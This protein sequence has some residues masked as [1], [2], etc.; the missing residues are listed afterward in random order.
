MSSTPNSDMLLAVINA[1][2]EPLFL[3]SS[4]HEL[5]FANSAFWSAVP[6]PTANGK[7]SLPTSLWFWPSS[8]LTEFSSEPFTSTFISDDKEFTVQLRALPV[9]SGHFLVQLLD[10]VKGIETNR[11]F[12]AQRLQTLGMLAG[13]VAHDFNNILTG[14][15][16]HVTYLKS[17]SHLEGQPLES[18]HSVEEGARKAS[19]IVQQIL[20]FSKME[21]SDRSQ[22]VNLTQLVNKTCRLLRGAISSKYRL[23]IAN[24]TSHDVTVLGLESKLAQ[25]LVN[26]VINARDACDREGLI[27]ITISEIKDSAKLSNLLSTEELPCDSYAVLKVEDNGHGMEP[28]VLERIFEPYFSTKA[29]RG[30]GIGLYTVLTIVKGFGGAIE[31]E[32]APNKG[33]AIS[34]YLPQLSQTAEETAV[35]KKIPRLTTTTKG[36]SI[37]VVDD[38][39]A[40]RNVLVLAL[41]H[42]GYQVES[43]SSGLEALAKYKDR[44]KFFDLVVMDM[45]MPQLSGEKTFFRLQELDPEVRVLLISGF[46]SEDAINAVLKSGGLGFI[47]KPFTIDVLAKKI[48]QC[49]ANG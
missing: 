12:H 28:E 1:L 14:I 18:L 30:T 41:Q 32:S 10:G 23:T 36:A 21:S 45:L 34:V 43:A 13:G 20:K 2:K 44:E 16:G 37:L 29:E 11:D 42:L 39:Y 15:L 35:P 4:D 17:A 47:Q 38:E 5:I 48:E 27:S 33:T 31:V 8:R 49:L 24:P 9:A 40:V 7:V 6:A 3:V 46:A 25:I 19:E 26:L 22:T